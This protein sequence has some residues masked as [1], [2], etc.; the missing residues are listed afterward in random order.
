VCDFYGETF[1]TTFFKYSL[2]F[3]IVREQVIKMDLDPDDIYLRKLFYTICLP[4]KPVPEHLQK[5][6]N[7]KRRILLEEKSEGQKKLFGEIELSF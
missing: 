6:D 1:F 3:D 4:F 7:L 2:V 5:L